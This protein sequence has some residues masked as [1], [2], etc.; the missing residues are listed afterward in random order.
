MNRYTPNQIHSKYVQA[1]IPPP[2][3]YLQLHPFMLCS[4]T[5]NYTTHSSQSSTT[6]KVKDGD[7][8][9]ANLQQILKALF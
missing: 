5:L 6:F 3:P 8:M 1:Y 2:S 7:Y 9:K 4:P